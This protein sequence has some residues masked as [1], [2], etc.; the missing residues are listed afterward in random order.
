LH[1]YIE[2]QKRT[3]T[4]HNLY[5]PEDLDALGTATVSPRRHIHMALP[6][7]L[8]HMP[9]TSYL[10]TAQHH[11]IAGSPHVARDV[12]LYLIRTWGSVSKTRKK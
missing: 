9:Y 2:K 10:D 3:I 7:T 1:I 11:G 4:V 5:E 6:L 8:L 12:R